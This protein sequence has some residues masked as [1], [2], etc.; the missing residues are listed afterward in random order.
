M[1]DVRVFIKVDV[2]P[3]G[4]GDSG[5]A[6]H[7]STLTAGNT[8]LVVQHTEEAIEIAAQKVLDMIKAVYPDT[9]G[10]GTHA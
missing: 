9:R 3:I 10:E 8:G 2:H 5:S 7:S 1:K 4:A 6:S